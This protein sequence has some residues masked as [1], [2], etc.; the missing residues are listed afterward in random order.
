[1]TITLG[2]LV[3]L[4]LVLA[5]VGF[6]LWLITAYI[7]MPAPFKQVIIVVAVLLLILWLVSATGVL[8]S[9]T[10]IFRR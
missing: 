5:L 6:V 3:G 2:G 8:T 7:P 1:M 10:P 9:G 4:L